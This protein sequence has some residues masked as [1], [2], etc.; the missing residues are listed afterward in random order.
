MFVRSA[1][2]DSDVGMRVHGEAVARSRPDITPAHRPGDSVGPGLLR[3]RPAQSP[4]RG[5]E[6]SAGPLSG[7]V[8]E[9][10]AQAPVAPASR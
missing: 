2:S 6:S 3:V 10:L 5:V 1:R 7:A 4:E 9:A 8:L